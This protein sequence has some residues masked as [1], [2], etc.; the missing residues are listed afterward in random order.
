[1]IGFSKGWHQSDAPGLLPQNWFRIFGRIVHE[2]CIE[3]TSIFPETLCRQNSQEHGLA[4]KNP[5]ESTSFFTDRVAFSRGSGGI[6]AT[7]PV[8]FENLI[9]PPVPIS[10]VSN[11]V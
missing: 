5:E 10:E 1:M 9:T 4:E 8:I 3:D 11:T 6:R 2:H 7:G